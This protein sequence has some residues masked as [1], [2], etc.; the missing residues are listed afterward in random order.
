MA[1][2]TPPNVVKRERD[3]SSSTSSSSATITSQPNVRTPLAHEPLS[4]MLPYTPSHTAT[5]HQS[6]GNETVERYDNT[7]AGSSIAP[8]SAASSLPK[9]V[10]RPEPAMLCGLLRSKPAALRAHP[11][12]TYYSER[13]YPTPLTAPSPAA[14][15]AQ[16]EVIRRRRAEMKLPGA[17]TETVAQR[18]HR[19][20]NE[21]VSRYRNERTYRILDPRFQMVSFPSC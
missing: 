14:I 9:Y 1:Q 19:Q 10:T 16:V 20:A 18:R 3:A 17:A 4:P 5:V 8:T 6:A 7:M 15:A 13:S 2:A 12:Q 21:R 11:Q